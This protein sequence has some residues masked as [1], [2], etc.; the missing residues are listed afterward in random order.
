MLVL[1]LSLSG[2]A[3]A[4]YFGAAVPI[5]AYAAVSLLVIGLTLIAAT[6]FGRPVVC[7]RSGVLL[8]GTVLVS[9]A[10]GPQS[11][12]NADA[13]AARP[14]GQPTRQVAKLPP[15]GDASGLRHSRGGSESAQADHRH[16]VQARVDVGE[17]KVLVPKGV[18]VEIN[19]RIDL[20][21]VE[22]YDQLVA[23]G[24]DLNGVVPRSPT[25]GPGEPTL[26]LD[27]A[28]DLG[29]VEVQR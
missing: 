5:M 6:R 10:L 26:K 17:L 24:A 19:Y 11:T 27:L 7:S 23:E 16:H 13:P 2:L 1:G 3:V 9:S 29:S 18:P 4:D 25:A 8:A 21:K 15:A 14:A 28:V 12:G 22:A 20:G